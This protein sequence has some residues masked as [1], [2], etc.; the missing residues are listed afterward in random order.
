MRKI[1][2]Q[3]IPN[4]PIMLLSFT[5][6]QLRDHFKN[7]TEFCKAFMV[8]ETYIINKLQNVD[9]FYDQS[10]NQFI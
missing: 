10:T 2:S 8:D 7:L 9:Y 5:N 1:M 3:S 6:T 4:D